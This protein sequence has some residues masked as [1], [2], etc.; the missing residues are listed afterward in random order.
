M[1]NVF[2]EKMKTNFSYRP[3]T[4]ICFIRCLATFLSAIVYL[5]IS[6]TNSIEV[7]VKIIA[8]TICMCCVVLNLYFVIMS[9]FLWNS[10]VDL[11]AEKM[12]QKQFGKTIILELSK[13][14]TVEFKSNTKSSWL[15]FKSGKNV[16]KIDRGSLLYKKLLDLSEHTTLYEKIRNCQGFWFV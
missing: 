7:S 2:G 9:I 10:R 4:V 8:I 6:L 15:I 11:T 16:I 5:A 13:I 14:E 1:I 12:T 3:R